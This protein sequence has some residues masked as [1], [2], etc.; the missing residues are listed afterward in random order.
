MSKIK[1]RRGLVRLTLWKPKNV[2]WIDILSKIRFWYFLFC[3]NPCRMPNFK[4]L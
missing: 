3:Y 4:R 2:I 1:K